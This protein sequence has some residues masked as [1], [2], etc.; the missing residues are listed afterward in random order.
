ML[1]RQKHLIPKFVRKRR[2]ESINGLLIGEFRHQF[3]AA[4]QHKVAVRL[5]GF[6]DFGRF[7][8]PLAAR[9]HEQLPPFELAG[10]DKIDSAE[11]GGPSDLCRCF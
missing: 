2:G 5:D 6:E 8:R 3:A 10:G 11:A 9:A 1:R 7:D 4:A